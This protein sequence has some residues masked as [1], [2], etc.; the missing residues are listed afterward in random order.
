MNKIKAV[1]LAGGAG[2]RLSP[3]TAAM[4][5]PLVPIMGK[6]AVA[7]TLALLRRN[8]ITSALVTLGYMADDMERYFSEHGAE[9]VSLRIFRESTP[10]GTAGALPAIADE[11]DDTFIV[12]SA[13]AVCDFNLSAALDFNRAK[14]VKFM[15]MKQKATGAI[16][17]VS[18]DIMPATAMRS[19]AKSA[20]STARL[21]I[22][23][24]KHILPTAPPLPMAL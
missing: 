11:L 3:V 16:S 10:L 15:L 13:D 6:P 24:K 20:A 1:I 21:I 2:T 8:G 22:S 5:K 18:T 7:R 9:G 23:A 12:I 17:E 19:A 4:P 14:G